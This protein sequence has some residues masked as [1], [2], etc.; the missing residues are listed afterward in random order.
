VTGSGGE[1]SR[2]LRRVFSAT[3]DRRNCRGWSGTAALR[4]VLGAPAS[5]FRAYEREMDGVMMSG[6]ELGM[7]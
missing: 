5:G 7:V 4:R 1:V 2:R 6:M 3:S